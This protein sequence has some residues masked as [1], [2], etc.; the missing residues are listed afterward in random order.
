MKT[1]LSH[2]IASG[3]TVRVE[4]ADLLSEYEAMRMEIEA[5]VIADCSAIFGSGPR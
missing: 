1:L 2:S 4:D 5:D 3:A